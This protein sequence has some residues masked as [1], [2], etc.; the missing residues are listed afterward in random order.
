MVWYIPGGHNYQKRE[1]LN[2]AV[3]LETHVSLC[4][5]SIKWKNEIATLVYTV[6]KIKFQTL[7][8]LFFSA[9]WFEQYRPRFD[10]WMGKIPWRRKWQPTPV[11]LPGESHGGRS[12]VGYVHGVA[13]SQLFASSGQSIEASALASVLPKSIQ[14]W[15]PLRLTG[16]ISLLS[17]GLSRIFS[18]ITV[19]KH[20]FFATQPSLWSSFHLRTS[21]LEKPCMYVS[22]SVTFNSLQPH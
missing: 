13:K 10:P 16:L 14:G 21:L 12:L 1:K 9:D 6:Y 17:K 3:H 20:Q 15:F 2:F 8:F 19:Q 4:S 22:G 7:H 5:L 18:S 11:L